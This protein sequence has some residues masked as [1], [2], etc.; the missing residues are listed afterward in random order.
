MIEMQLM[1]AILENGVRVCLLIAPMEKT[2]RLLLRNEYVEG[3]E[4]TLTI[5]PNCHHK[6]RRT[7]LTAN[8]QTSPQ[9]RV[10]MYKE[11]STRL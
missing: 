11:G 1:I 3:R 2:S 4:M 7:Q 9:R 6:C 5:I 10:T 8:F